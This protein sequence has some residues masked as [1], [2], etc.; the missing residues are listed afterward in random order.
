MN[1]IKNNGAPSNTV[2][3]RQ[4]QNKYLCQKQLQSDK[5]KQTL[6]SKQALTFQNLSRRNLTNRLSLS[7]RQIAS[8][9]II[10]T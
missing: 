10:I 1:S 7:W 6:L 3:L 9:R 8:N 4:N 2:C 5:I